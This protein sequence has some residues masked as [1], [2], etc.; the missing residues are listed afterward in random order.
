MMNHKNVE[1]VAYSPAWKKYF[2]KEKLGLTKL[3]RNN[4]VEVHHIGSTAITSIVAKPTLDILVEVHTL[5]G[6]EAFKSEFE[7]AGL[8]LTDEFDRE[9]RLYFIR[10]AADGITHL[11]HIHIFDRSSEHIQNHLDFRDYLNAEIEVAKEYE[12]LKVTLKEK[13]ENS[14]ELYSAGKNEFIT[15]VLKNIT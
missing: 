11:S 12:N 6:I 4:L 8:I 1:L 5:D 13:F 10:L 15:T 7:R 9:E 14:P 3:L 2:E